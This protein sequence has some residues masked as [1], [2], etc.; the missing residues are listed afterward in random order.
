MNCIFQ[1]HAN[2]GSVL[3]TAVIRY[4][5]IL[6]QTGG[7]TVISL[8][9]FL[10]SGHTVLKILHLYESQLREDAHSTIDL[11]HCNFLLQMIGLLEHNDF[12]TSQSQR[13]RA[14]YYLMVR[15]YPS[16]AFTF[17][18]RIKSL[19]RTE[20]KF[21][22]YIIEYISDY[23]EQ[24]G[25]LPPMSEV[26]QRLHMFRDLIAY[27]L[28]ISLPRC[29]LK[30]GQNLETEELRYLYE[31]ANQ[32]PRFLE[33]HGFTPEPAGS[34][35]LYDSPLDPS[36]RPYYRDYVASPKPFGYRSL[37]ITFFDNMARCHIEIQ[38]RTKQMDDN[39]TIGPAN[40]LGYEQRQQEERARRETVPVGIC[41]E[42]DE[43]WERQTAIQEIDLSKVDVNMFSA[44][45]QA[46]INDGCGLYRGR[47]ITP[48]EHLSKFQN[49]SIS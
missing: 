48:F 20:G 46:L 33:E 29:N 12:L 11:A 42:F 3:L 7:I 34:E 39:A 25:A 2:H 49:D 5:I 15:Q 14:F 23:Y 47:L 43:A 30:P 24:N 31:I 8:N 28:V 9:D 32:L 6:N 16:L 36:V 37:H 19:V 10:Y 13:I 18:G 45:S 35:T 17:K 22:G 41:P 40:H 38:L 4:P 27:R 1:F 26:K 44:Y 21:N